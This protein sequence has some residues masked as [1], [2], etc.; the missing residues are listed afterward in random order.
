M[1]RNG[2]QLRSD[3]PA[4]GR[5]VARRRAPILY[6][7]RTDAATTKSDQDDDGTQTTR[8]THVLAHLAH[9]AEIFELYTG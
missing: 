5:G 3:L 2:I 7:G 4:L 9:K 6:A 1:T 8:R